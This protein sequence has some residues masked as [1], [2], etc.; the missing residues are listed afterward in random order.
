V[1]DLAF[2]PPRDLFVLDTPY[3]HRIVFNSSLGT[4]STPERYL[5][6]TSQNSSSFGGLAVDGYRNLY[7]SQKGSGSTGGRILMYPFDT[8]FANRYCEP[9]QIMDNLNQPGDLELSKD[10][11]SLF[12]ATAGGK[13]EKRIFGVTGQVKDFFGNP[14]AGAVVS[15]EVEP[16]GYSG[17]ARTDANGFYR[18]DSVFRA[19]LINPYLDL[20]VEYDGKTQVF[21]TMLGQPNLASYG[22]TIRNI[23][24]NP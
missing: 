9:V 8:C 21:L 19:D 6:L 17:T 1:Q 4:P 11:R 20:T 5:D 3:V 22:H 24:F 10:G 12:I 15:Y 2:G 7:L 16:L 13:L 23:T 14:L 18:F